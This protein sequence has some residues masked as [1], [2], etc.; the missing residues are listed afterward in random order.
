MLE[1]NSPDDSH[2]VTKGGIRNF[3]VLRLDKLK[4]VYD[5]AGVQGELLKGVS[6][7]RLRHRSPEIA[8][9]YGEEKRV[10]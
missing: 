1:I 8:Q 2:T 10:I 4:E 9:A 5:P 3:K 7:E 6:Q